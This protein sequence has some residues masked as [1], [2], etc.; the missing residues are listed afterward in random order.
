MLREL[1]R[2]STG[3]RPEYLRNTSGIRP[4]YVGNTT[5]A[6]DQ[7][8]FGTREDHDGCLIA[9]KFHELPQSG[10]CFPGFFPPSVWGRALR[11]HFSY[12]RK[13]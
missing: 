3:I 1:D 5:M 2:N 13:T 12:G 6:A 11:G 10:D 7:T 8:S 9:R 4:E